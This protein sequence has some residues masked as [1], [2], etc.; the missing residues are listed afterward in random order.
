MQLPIA[1][2]TDVV[3]VWHVKLSELCLYFAQ[4]LLLEEALQAESFLSWIA[5]LDCLC[6]A[7][8]SVVQSPIGD[9]SQ[10]QPGICPLSVILSSTQHAEVMKDPQTTILVAIG[11]CCVGNLCAYIYHMVSLCALSGSRPITTWHSSPSG[12][13]GPALKPACAAVRL[14][15]FGAGGLPC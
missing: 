11:H 13:G 3:D 5:S 10:A 6:V 8:A 14:R 1:L 12:T 15:G 9:H 7:C 2:L 4:A